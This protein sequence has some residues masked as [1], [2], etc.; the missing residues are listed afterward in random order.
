MIKILVE[1]PSQA[2]FP[3]F[4]QFVVLLDYAVIN[5]HM[6]GRPADDGTLR[7]KDVQQIIKEAAKSAAQILKPPP[8]PK[9]NETKNGAAVRSLGRCSVGAFVGVFLGAVWFCF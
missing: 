3:H 9:K 7:Y 5:K 8:P 4:R 2:F 1:T 6:E